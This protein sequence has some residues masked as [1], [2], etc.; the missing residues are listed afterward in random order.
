MIEG[1]LRARGVMMGR[2]L[3]AMR[4]VPRH[5]FVSHEHSKR[6]YADEALGVGDGQTISQPYVVGVM[7]QELDVKEG[8]RVLEIGTGT[9]YQTAILAQ[10]VGVNGRVYTIE[11][12][13]GLAAFARGRLEALGV[14]HVE[15]FVGDGSAGWR[16]VLLDGEGEGLPAMFDRIMVTAGCPGGR[17]PLVGQLK[18]GGMMVLPVGDREGQM[19]R[20]VVK[21]EDGG[22]EERDFWG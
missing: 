3:E 16:G 5:L 14:T 12:K 19:L 11:R 15:F 20:R 8:M 9:G 7:T 2:V 17:G 13:E 4:A 21:R 18:V 1:Q 22:V 6:A 10:L